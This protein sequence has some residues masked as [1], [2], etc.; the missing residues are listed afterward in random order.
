M[1]RSLL[2]VYN[3]NKAEEESAEQPKNDENAQEALALDKPA[4]EISEPA[5][6]TKRRSTHQGKSSDAKKIKKNGMF[7]SKLNQ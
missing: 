2:S 4:I 5:T 7:A 1:N 3:Q 6:V